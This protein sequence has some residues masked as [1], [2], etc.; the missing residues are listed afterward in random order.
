MGGG[1][2]SAYP[3]ST[4]TVGRPKRRCIV[5]GCKK[6]ALAFKDKIPYCRKHYNKGGEE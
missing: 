5:E 6:R 2:N 3:K 4:C 1:Q